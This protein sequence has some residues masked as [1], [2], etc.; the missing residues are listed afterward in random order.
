MWKEH[1]NSEHD[2]DI[3]RKFDG[4]AQM[5]PNELRKSDAIRQNSA[6]FV[7]PSRSK[8]RCFQPKLADDEKQ[9]LHDVLDIAQGKFA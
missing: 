2:H 5:K 1:P 8:T 9:S 3:H 7:K 4:Y 6:A